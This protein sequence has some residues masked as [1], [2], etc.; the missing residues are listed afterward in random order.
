MLELL[1]DLAHLPAL[2]TTLI[3]QALAEHLS[4]LNESFSVKENVKRHY[5]V[6]CVEDIREV[7]YRSGLYSY[8]G[9]IILWWS[10]VVIYISQVQHYSRL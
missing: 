10:S 5:V 1:W 8:T 9:N 3:E 2:R 7:G 6:K 4:I